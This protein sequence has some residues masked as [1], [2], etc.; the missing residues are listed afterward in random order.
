MAEAATQ[1]KSESAP[2]AGGGAAR[3]QP[4]ITLTEG[5]LIGGGLTVVC[6]INLIPIA[7]DITAPVAGGLMFFYL[8][9]KGLRGTNVVATNIVGYAAGMFPIVQALPTP[10]VAWVVVIII[11]R[12]PVVEKIAEKAE[13]V[14]GGGEA[15][16][17]GGAAA[18]GAAVEGA[19]VEGAAA[20]GAAGATAA[21][22][23]VP[24]GA[25]GGA[26]SAQTGISEGGA[27]GPPPGTEGPTTPEAGG[28]SPIAGEEMPPGEAGATEEGAGKEAE[29]EKEYRE[30]EAAAAPA[31][32]PPVEAAIKEEFP[33]EAAGIQ[34]LTEKAKETQATEDKAEDEEE[35]AS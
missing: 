3:S 23:G 21:A 15:G 30:I 1:P 26:P 20:G 6:V 22:E 7:G 34:A 11:D 12:M 31:M 19:A 10:L 18:E 14:T 24:A 25:A 17:L 13:V 28:P 16:A 8:Y 27:T 4:K 9:M 35:P 2:P 29:A 5:L 32:V 33:S